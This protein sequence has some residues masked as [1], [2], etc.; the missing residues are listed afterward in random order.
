MSELA[1]DAVSKSSIVSEVLAKE[2]LEFQ[3]CHRV[4]GFGATF[5]LVPL[6]INQPAEERGGK[7]DAVGPVGSS[8]F[9]VIITLLTKLVVIQM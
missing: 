7:R 9:K 1:A 5:M 6:L 4:H 2:V 3:L 8:S